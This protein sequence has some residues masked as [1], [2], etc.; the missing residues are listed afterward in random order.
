MA[1]IARKYFREVHE[2][3]ILNR[4]KAIIE[5]SAV[6]SIDVET[7]VE[8]ANCYVEL[9]EKVRESRMRTPSLF[10]AVVLAAARREGTKIFNWRQAS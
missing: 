1:E 6:A 7:A 5:V 9:F 10:D 3:T 8:S 2:E 4:S